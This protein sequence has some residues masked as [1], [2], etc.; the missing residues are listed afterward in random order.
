MKTDRDL[1]KE[2]AGIIRTIQSRTKEEST[3]IILDS[4]ITFLGIAL[5]ED[6][7]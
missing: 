6:D 7:I 1:Y 4:S 5:G 3:R 2:A